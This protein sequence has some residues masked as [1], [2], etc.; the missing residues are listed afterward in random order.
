[1]IQPDHDMVLHVFSGFITVTFRQGGNNFFMG[2][3][4]G[5]KVHSGYGQKPV[6]GKLSRL[7]EKLKYLLIPCFLINDPM[8]FRV[9]R[10]PGLGFSFRDFLLLFQ[11]GA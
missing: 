2:L 1:M 6:V 3:N 11:E 5:F 10:I 4:G 9:Q 8:E 7:T